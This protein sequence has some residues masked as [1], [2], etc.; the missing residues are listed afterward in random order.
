MG[1]VRHSSGVVGPADDLGT[2]GDRQAR[3]RVECILR[4]AVNR[5]SGADWTFGNRTSQRRGAHTVVVEGN[6]RRPRGAEITD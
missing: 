4:A 1:I 6:H 2:R 5:G 3:R